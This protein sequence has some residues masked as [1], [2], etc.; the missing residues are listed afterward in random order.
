M[1][2]VWPVSWLARSPRRRERMGEC[3]EDLYLMVTRIGDNHRSVHQEVEST[4]LTELAGTVSPATNAGQCSH[5]I[6]R[7]QADQAHSFDGF[8]QQADV[9]PLPVTRKG[10]RIA[11]LR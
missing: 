1:E 4:R 9:F 6:G 8:I 2:F 3:R 10:Y 7:I 5:F 11:Q